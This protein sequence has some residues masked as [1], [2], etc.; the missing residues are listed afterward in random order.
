MEMET[1]GVR[2]TGPISAATSRAEGNNESERR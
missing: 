1:K 2:R